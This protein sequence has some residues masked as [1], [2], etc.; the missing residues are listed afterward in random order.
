[1]AYHPDKSAEFVGL[2]RI[3]GTIDGRHGSL[4]LQHV[5]TF[6]DGAAKA[7][8]T[9]VSG[10]DELKGATG[11]PVRGRPGRPDH[12]HHRSLSRAKR[13]VLTPDGVPRASPDQMDTMSDDRP[14]T[15]ADAYALETPHDS[16]RLYARWA[17]TYES[18]F[19]ARNQYVIPD[20]V[21]EVFA[22]VA[23]RA[24]GVKGPVL[25]V[26]CGTGLV[27][28]A[29][30]R[31]T[32]G[33]G[34][35]WMIDGVDISPEMLAVVGR[36]RSRPDGRPLYRHLIEADLTAPVDIADGS[37][38]GVLSAGT[39]TH[40]H[41]G[42]EVLSALV[43]FGRPGALFAIG[44]NAEH[45]AAMGFAD[46][47]ADESA[48]ARSAISNRGSSTCTYP[49][50]SITA[51]R[52]SSPC[53]GGL[54]QFRARSIDVMPRPRLTTGLWLI[55]GLLSTDTRCMSLIVARRRSGAAAQIAR[56]VEVSSRRVCAVIVVV[57]CVHP[58]AVARRLV[59]TGHLPDGHDRCERGRL[60]QRAPHSADRAGSGWR[61]GSAHRPW[62]TSSTRRTCSSGTPNPTCRSPTAPWIASY[63]ALAVGMLQ[64]L[65]R[66][67]RR[68]RRDLDGSDRHGGDR[69]HRRAHPLAVLDRPPASAT[70][71]VPLFVRSV[72]AS[73]PILDAILLA[74]VLRTL[75]ELR[76]ELDDG[77]APRRRRRCAG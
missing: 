16:R 71:S 47:L 15:L 8:L 75:V 36:R 64:L 37:Y 11:G 49:A 34:V 32:A 12:P 76:V 46:Q 22:E 9:V 72:W 13:L 54:R 50:A 60:A 77:D 14:V 43:R 6:D 44:I 38:A 1:M 45:F 28:M 66:G 42:P 29:L 62:L 48:A 20:R 25:D 74:V 73:Y 30:V 4:V 27:G 23:G 56:P 10:T 65:R 31:D 69:P 35:D 59:R 55:P 68:T 51:R 63:V 5:G 19:V 17:A 57:L 61:S 52:P 21:A 41:L 58:R 18:E 33:D 53:S 40:G 3:K 24:G 2:E 70:R 26:G 67:H 39:F 7:T